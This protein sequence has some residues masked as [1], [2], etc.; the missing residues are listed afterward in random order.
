[1][2]IITNYFPTGIWYIPY[3]IEFFIFPQLVK[4]FD[5]LG[6]GQAI[7]YWKN[8]NNKALALK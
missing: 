6:G 4:I 3:P 1:M 8:K 7:I 5:D 2:L